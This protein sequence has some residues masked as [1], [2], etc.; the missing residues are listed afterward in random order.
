MYMTP[1]LRSGLFNVDP[2][3]LGVQF[4]DDCLQQRSDAIAL[5]IIEPDEALLEQLRDFGVE[6]NMSKRAL[7]AVKNA[8]VMEAMDY[9]DR[10][11]KELR[12]QIA[13]APIEDKKKK[14]MF[15]NGRL[16]DSSYLQRSTQSSRA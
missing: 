1:E 8:G 14:K 11:E 4:L 2:K 7:V 12:A 16:S 5:G 3:E 9:I 6:D 13:S 15:N 10:H